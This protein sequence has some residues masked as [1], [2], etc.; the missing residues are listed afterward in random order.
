MTLHFLNLQNRYYLQQIIGLLLSSLF[1]IMIYPKVDLDKSLI[2]PY[3]DVVSH[4]FLLKHHAFLEQFMH[5]TLKRVMIIVALSALLM[6]FKNSFSVPKP[7]NFLARVKRFF[8]SPYF[9]VF[10]GMVVS[11]S[12]VAFLKSINVHGC[13]SDLIPY[14]GHLPLLSLFEHLPSGVEAGH[15]FPGGHASGGFALMA[16]YYAFR[17]SQPKFASVMLVVA[18]LMGFSM[19]WAQMMRGEHFLS[20]NLWSAWV[21]WLVLFVLYFLKKQIEKN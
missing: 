17:D 11:T 14:G 2:A 1:L 7:H 8:A 18:I 12:T 10:I 15:C 16:F 20:H 6:A 13:P 19:G 21:V 5:L 3:F 4:R 9:F